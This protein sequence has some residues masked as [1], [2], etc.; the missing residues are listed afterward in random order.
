MSQDAMRVTR[1][2]FLVGLNLS[3][4]GLAIGLPALADEPSGRAGPGPRAAAPEDGPGLHPNPFVHVAPD[5]TVTL[6][7]HRSEM[8]QGVRSTIP[9]L[10]ADE[11]GAD[12]KRV[13][14]RQADGDK[15][16]GDQ[17]TDG[18]SSIRKFY[19]DLRYVAATARTMLV[20]AAAAK[21]KVKPETCEARGNMVVHA[22]TKRSLGFGELAEAA[23]KLPVPKRADVKLRPKSE[24][25]WANSTSLPLLDGPA[26]VTG[27]A[28]FGADLKLPDMLIAVIAR[29]PV[30]GGKVARYDATR[31]LQIPGVKRVVEMP[32]A[33][34]P[35]GFQPWGGIAVLAENTW[36][37]MRGRAALDI[38]WDPGDNAVYDSVAYR[39]TLLASVHAPGTTY[40]NVGDVDA[41]FAK[42]AR[43]VEA[44]YVVPH[45]AH[46]SM[47]PP[48]ALARVSGGR[49]EVW[50]PTQHPQAA[51]TQVAK[52]LGLGEDVVT[53]HVTLLGGGFGRKSKADFSAEAAF[54]A[55]EAGVPVRVQW[56]REDDIHHDYYNTVNA[57]QIRAGLDANG[58][59]IAW[60][61][62]T[63]FPPISSLFSDNDRPGIT[64]LQQG[65]LDLAIDV[66][67]VRAE[68]CQA[69]PHVRIGWY[70]SVYNIFHA[71]GIGS[72]IDEI[73]HARGADP[74][75]VWLDIIG[76]PRI[77]GL[78]ALGVEKLANYGESLEKHP[79]DAGRLRRVIERVTA[80]ANW[81]GRKKD[82]RGYGL[83]AHRSFVSYTAVVL[84]VV[85]D[86]RNKVRVDEAWI[87]MDAGLVVNQE[88][89]HAQMQGSVVM[90][91]SNALFG[92][93]TMKD[94][95]TQQSNFR[96][97]RIA[98]IG[99]VPRKIHV[100]LVPSDSPP[101]GVGEP[102]VP[103][104]GPALANAVFALTGKRIREIPLVR[105][106]SV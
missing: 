95:A 96:D 41:A 37:A 101:C 104:V 87:C 54:L 39:D 67:N 84:A 42:A 94:G 92:G 9:V 19:D 34:R 21:W 86:E 17:N 100:D 97:A 53:V 52:T 85:P 103:P 5:G 89:A 6:V 18:S 91:I 63:A 65:V 102:G 11:L 22:P 70:R 38:T 13:V 47:E 2:S 88:R 81:S 79:V 56:T 43:I 26:Y 50:A 36:A 16:Y 69:K 12:M 57:Q 72:L 66:P 27:Q 31:A 68:A 23:G 3:L 106:L 8:G 20:A 61:H 99:E 1:R 73:A 59:V 28:V 93:I 55:R 44:D 25:G 83:A 51:R 24:L 40:R 76:P 45:L 46:L 58:K 35:Y 74:R 80:S 98:R 32:A 71:F 33:M 105:G 49:C 4:A 7:C 90:G 60:R 77:M 14:I 78:A 64:D 48:A 30:V 75:E 62:R 29:P 10:F 82:G 15:K